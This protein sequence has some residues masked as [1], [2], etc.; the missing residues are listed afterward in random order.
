MF[1]CHP[2]HVQPLLAKLQEGVAIAQV[3]G[4]P[5][6]LGAWLLANVAG[7]EAV[8]AAVADVPAAVLQAMGTPARRAAIRASL[9]AG[10][11]P[12]G[13]GEL[14][15][16]LL[17]AASGSLATMLKWCDEYARTVAVHGADTP[18]FPNLAA[19]VGEDFLGAN[20]RAAAAFPGVIGR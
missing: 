9:I 2:S 8:L 14:V 11:Q 12:A 1:G 18:V 5:A 6:T 4:A 13:L 16:A 17:T 20:P 10:L 3:L 19:L 7:C 15:F